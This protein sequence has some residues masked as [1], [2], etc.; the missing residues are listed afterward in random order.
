MADIYQ[1]QQAGSFDFG[2]ALSRT[3]TIIGDNFKT[4]LLLTFLLSGLSSL[5]INTVPYFISSA[6]LSGGD[7]AWLSVFNIDDLSGSAALIMVV[8][9]LGFLLVYLL[10]YATLQGAV[11]HTCM[12][13]YD[14][15][16]AS[17]SESLAVGWSSVW[18]MLGFLI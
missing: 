2:R 11:F 14:G 17:V 12:R 4:L 5:L 6:A 1:D 7:M 10:A 3:F 16:S 8:A 15:S 18:P 13:D 9:L